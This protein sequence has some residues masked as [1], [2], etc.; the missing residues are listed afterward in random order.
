[1][2]GEEGRERRILI[3]DTA[4]FISFHLAELLLDQGNRVHGYDGMTNYYDVRLKRRRHQ[5]LLQKPAFTATEALLEDEQ[6]LA[7]VASEFQPEVIIHLAAQAGVRYSLEEPRTYI[8]SNL[9]L[10]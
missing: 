10:L 1:M 6:I 7:A 9:K 4:G 3:T 5:R 8:E 2:V